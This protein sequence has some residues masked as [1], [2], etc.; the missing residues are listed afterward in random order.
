MN[1]YKFP[2]YRDLSRQGRSFAYLTN[3]PKNVR[4]DALNSKELSFTL[5]DIRFIDLISVAS[6]RVDSSLAYSILF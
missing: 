6:G 1:K 5:K 3:L 4:L 2:I